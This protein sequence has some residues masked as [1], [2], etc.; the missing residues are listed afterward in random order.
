MADM[1]D[2]D[3]VDSAL[4]MLTRHRVQRFTTVGWTVEFQPERPPV[5][6]LPKDESEDKRRCICGHDLATEHNQSGCLLCT[7]Q[8]MT[9]ENP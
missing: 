7:G 6:S 1:P 3:L 9:Q 8:C 5:E 2:M 4:A